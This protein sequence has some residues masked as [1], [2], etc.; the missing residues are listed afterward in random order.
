MQ[1][2]PRVES[3]DLDSTTTEAPVPAEATSE[4]AGESDILWE[5]T[6]PEGEVAVLYRET[7]EHHIRHRRNNDP[8]LEHFT[9]ENLQCVHTD[10]DMKGQSR[11]LPHRVSSYKSMPCFGTKN[12]RL[13]KDNRYEP[14]RVV[15]FWVQPGIDKHDDI[16][17]PKDEGGVE[18]CD[19]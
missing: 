15:T 8:Y 12:L 5:A 13:G 7:Y 6:D 19:E 9:P 16:T 1:D 3:T 14:T 2:D 18:S 10:P 4:A 17:W 11:D